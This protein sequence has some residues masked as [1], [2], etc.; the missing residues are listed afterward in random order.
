VT[1][2][3][4]IVTSFVIL[5]LSAG[6]RHRDVSKAP[7]G[8]ATTATQPSPALAETQPVSVPFVDA[9]H[10]L[11]FDYPATWHPV[12]DDTILTLVPV[13]ETSIGHR[14]LV[15]DAPDL[16]LHLPGLIPL[17]AVESG[18]VDD[19]KS[20]GTDVN[21]VAADP[22]VTWPGTKARW[23]HGTAKRKDDGRAVVIQTVVIVRGD[24]VI[25]ID[26]ESDPDYAA[27][28]AAGFQAIVRSLQWT[29]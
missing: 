6:C 16:P 25:V 26:A 28:T 13:N 17:G 1:I 21:I 7:G 5:A 20:R 18:F 10:G 19:V 2:R 29:N 24:T 23:L 15:I 22:L 4:C 8:V 9:K 3:R 27:A 12:K 11:R 14:V